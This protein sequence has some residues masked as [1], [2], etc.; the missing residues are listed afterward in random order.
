M[1]NDNEKIQIEF[2]NNAGAIFFDLLKNFEATANGLNRQTEEYKFQ[3]L[4]EAYIHSMKQQLENCAT[5][6]MQQHRHNR[7]VNELSQKLQQHI[8]QYLHLFVQKTRAI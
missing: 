7:K 3:Q 1:E 6:L 4:K 2:H 8:K 5:L